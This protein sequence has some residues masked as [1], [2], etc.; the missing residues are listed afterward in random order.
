MATEDEIIRKR[1]LVD[2][3][4]VSNDDRRINSIVKTFVKWCNS[5]DGDEDDSDSEHQ[6]TLFS[7]EQCEFS[8]AKTQMIMDMN[9]LELWMRIQ[10][11]INFYFFFTGHVLYAMNTPQHMYRKN[12]LRA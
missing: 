6:K 12:T 7:L 2:G 5:K 4:G 8:F 11:H 1:L 10:F 3:D 9:Q